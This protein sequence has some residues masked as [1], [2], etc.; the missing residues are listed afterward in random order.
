LDLDR[1]NGLG[2]VFLGASCW[3]DE[4]LPCSTFE[5]A[6]VEVVMN[7]VVLS[8][9]KIRVLGSSLVKAVLRFTHMVC[10]GV[11]AGL[12]SRRRGMPAVWFIL[13]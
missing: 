5:L 8:P 11:C 9:S 7:F 2:L 4:S 6:A 1:L 10:F 13:N 3:C 12:L